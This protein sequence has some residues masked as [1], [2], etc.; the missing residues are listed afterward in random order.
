ML[1]I[2][3]IGFGIVAAVNFT[4]AGLA[5]RGFGGVVVENSYVAS[6]KFNGW[7][8][9]ASRQQSLD[10]GAEMKRND[11]GKLVVTASNIPAT[12]TARVELRRPLGDP[13]RQSIMLKRGPGELFVSHSPFD[14]GRWLA[15]LTISDGD[16]S[17]SIEEELR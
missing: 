2:F 3:A 1:A 15:R 16:T 14:R 10:W 6:Q 17:W 9:A 5:T 11:D 13:A 8:D 4:M 12:A 7:L